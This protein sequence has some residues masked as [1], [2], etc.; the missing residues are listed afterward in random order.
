MPESVLHFRMERH[1]DDGVYFVISGVEIALV[2]E[3][4]TPEEAF[5]NLREAVALYYE[6]DNLRDS[7]IPEEELRSHFYTD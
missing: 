3:G 6:G 5:R 4:E 7:F 2:T 1:E